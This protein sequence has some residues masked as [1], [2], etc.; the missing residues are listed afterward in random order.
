M[1]W[2]A[3]HYDFDRDHGLAIRF[4]NDQGVSSRY[5]LAFAKWLL[6]HM[7]AAW[8]VIGEAKGLAERVAHPPTTAALHTIAAW[9]DC[10]RG[11]H[12]RA[13]ANA[14][15]AISLARSFNLPL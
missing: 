10:V 15:K 14:E 8:G 7:G 1:Q 4:T 2:A 11:D 13:R 3:D 5:Y 6:G 9:L 12:A